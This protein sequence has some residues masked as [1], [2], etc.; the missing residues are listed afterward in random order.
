M[1]S[2]C[3]DPGLLPLEEA[4][5]RL[6]AAIPGP[7]H[8]EVLADRDD[9]ALDRS[10]MDGAAMRVADGAAPRLIL[11]T[12]F[13]GDDPGAFTVGAGAAVRIMTGACIPAGADTV[14]PVEQLGE[15]EGRLIPADA[16]RPG[17]HIRRRGSHARKGEVLLTAGSPT[18][19]A[20]VGLRAQVGLP[21]ADLR[22]VR[23]G[24]ASTG[25]ELA[26]DPRPHQIRDSNGPM[27]EALAH[28]LGAEVRRLPSLPDDEAALIARLTD[29]GGVQVLLTSGGVSMGEKD[30]LP[31]VLKGL[32]AEILFHKIR[33]KPGKPMLAAKLG[34]TVILGLPGNPVSAYLNTLLFLPVALARLE[35]RRISDPWKH[36][37]LTASVK[38][39]GDRPLLHPCRI[40]GSRVMPV[41]SRGSGDL[42][43]LAR[44]HACAWI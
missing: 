6:A 17:D 32:G 28:N 4:L 25:D 8:E 42:V 38:N 29:L 9:P 40:E 18:S 5:T 21:A 2:S 33:L 34:G 14:V 39:R 43:A 36:G 24:I 20:V 3:D 7:G 26:A 31:E 15:A 41:E 44:A 27:L 13:A 11:G 1:A 23:V 10:A 35:G 37:E 19:A 16:P 22:R 12:L 30:L